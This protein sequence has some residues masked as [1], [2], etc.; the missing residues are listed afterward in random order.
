VTEHALDET[1]L[2]KSQLTFLP[3]GLL[4]DL[5]NS[6]QPFEGIEPHVGEFKEVLEMVPCLPHGVGFI[7]AKFEV[8]ARNR[9]IDVQEAR[10]T[11]EDE[12][13]LILTELPVLA[14]DPAS[15]A[16]HYPERQRIAEAASD[17]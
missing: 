8:V 11:H 4:V 3:D 16:R 10:N 13:S 14:A 5:C 7:A 15:P 6:R 12:A 1:L 9:T 2:C 17:V